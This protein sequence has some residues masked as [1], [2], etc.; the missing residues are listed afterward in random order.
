M[1]DETPADP[2]ALIDQLTRDNA[3]LTSRLSAAEGERDGFRTKLRTNTH[4][5]A[6]TDAIR[7]AK[8]DPKAVEALWRLHGYEPDS[9]DVDPA[10]IAELVTRAKEE[11]PFAFLK[12]EPAP[13]AEDPSKPPPKLKKPT[14]EGRGTKPPTVAKF[15]VTRQQLA[16]GRWMHQNQE[17]VQKAQGDGTF[18]LVD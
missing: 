4:K 10:A 1:P 13:A 8:A 5:Q 7:G 15:Q 11:S 14:D 6:F 9:D 17:K 16:D 3:S 2:Q 18:E 12:D